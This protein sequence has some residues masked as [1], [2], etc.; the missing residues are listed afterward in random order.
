[1]NYMPRVCGNFETTDST[2][3]AIS[4]LESGIDTE[5]FKRFVKIASSEY[6]YMRTY[7]ERIS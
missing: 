6:S 3:H 4:G 5:K 1:M 7:L 2:A